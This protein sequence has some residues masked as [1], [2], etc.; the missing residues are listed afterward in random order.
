M[1]VEFEPTY[2]DWEALQD[3]IRVLRAGGV[4][5]IP[6]DTRYALV[7]VLEQ[8]K[9]VRKMAEVKKADRTK[10][11]SILCADLDEAGRYIEGMSSYAYRSCKSLLPGPYTLVLPAGRTIPK[12]LYTKQ[13]TVGL[14]VPDNEL[15]RT[16]VEQLRSP[17]ACTS[18]PW[19]SEQTPLQ[20]GPSVHADWGEK[21]DLVVGQ[22][23]CLVQESTVVDLTVHPPLILREGIGDLSYFGE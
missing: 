8:P 4:A 19:D 9:A 7:C 23:S 17:L 12:L 10:R 15:I 18:L 5:A 6:T 22:G 13:R 2:L 20:D 21:V 3:L 16:L 1:L 11:F 14:R